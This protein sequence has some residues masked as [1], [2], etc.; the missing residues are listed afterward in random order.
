VQFGDQLHL[1]GGH[2]QRL[3]RE[4]DW[5]RQQGRRGG[6]LDGSKRTP[7][8]ADRGGGLGSGTDQGVSDLLVG[9]VWMVAQKRCTVADRQFGRCLDQDV[10]QPAAARYC[11]GTGGTGARDQCLGERRN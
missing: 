7:A 4:L 8:G 1:D 5:Q 3:D 2:N 9:L 11:S 6:E 10:G